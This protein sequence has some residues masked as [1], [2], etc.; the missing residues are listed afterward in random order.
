MKTKCLL[1]IVFVSL[2]VAANNVIAGSLKIDRIW[3]EH[4]YAYALVSYKNDSDKTFKRFVTVECTAIDPQGNKINI[5]KRSF[6]S[7]DYGPI[8]PGFEGTVKI[9]I[10]LNEKTLKSVECRALGR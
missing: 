3:V 5:N 1:T 9:P 10:R 7:H 8:V 2:L 6:F 4:D